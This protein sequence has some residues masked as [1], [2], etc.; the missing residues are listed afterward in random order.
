[1]T[2]KT[3]KHPD[4]SDISDQLLL[5]RKEAWT[6]HIANV[7]QYADILLLCQ[8]LE[9]AR[10]TSR[11]DQYAL[12]CILIVANATG[13]LAILRFQ[14]FEFNF[15]IVHGAG[16]KDQAANVLSRSLANGSD[17]AVFEDDIPIS[18]VT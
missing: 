7:S 18:V 14:L 17:R 9:G 10:P 16:I 1:M 15:N 6:L 12:P 4:K 8:I 13:K 5:N 11:T 3:G 2:G